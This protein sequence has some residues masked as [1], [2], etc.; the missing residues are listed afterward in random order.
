MRDDGGTENS[1]ILKIIE[2]YNHGDLTKCYIVILTYGV[3][4]AGRT[5]LTLVMIEVSSWRRGIRF[6]ILVCTEKEKNCRI[7]LREAF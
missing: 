6:S 5:E 4:Q 7:S 3:L 2:V 1:G